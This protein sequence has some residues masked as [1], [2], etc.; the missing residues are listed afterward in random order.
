MLTVDQLRSLANDKQIETVYMTFTDHIGRQMG[1][2]YDVD[3]FLEDGIAGSYA[4]EYLLTVD[5]DFN[6]LPG[7]SYT[8]WD[9]GYGDFKLIPDLSTLRHASWLDKTAYVTCDVVNPKTKGLVPIAPRSILRKQIGRLQEAGYTAVGASELEY[10]MYKDSYEEAFKKGYRGLESYGYYLA[11]YHMLQSTREEKLNAVMRRHLKASG[12]PVE[13]SKG[14][15]GRGQHELNVRYADVLTMSDRHTVYKQ[16]FK[17]VASQMGMSVTF[18]A[19]PHSDQSGNSCHL[20]V[21]LAD[22]NGRNIFAGNEDFYGIKCSPFFRYFLGGWIKHTPSLMPFYAPTINSYKRFA[23]ASWAPTRLGWSA[24]N[25][26]AG[27][28]IVG[29]GP[30]LRIECRLPGAD[31]NPYLA[32]SA[33]VASGL[34]GILNKIEPDDPGHENLDEDPSIPLLPRTLAEATSLFQKSDF[35]RSTFGNDVVDHYAHFFD[36]ECQSFDRAVTD[37]ERTRYFEQI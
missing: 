17:E 1:K 5:T 26:T 30:S 20:H 22:P 28:R 8:N 3:Y 24:D 33:A 15:Y 36:S 19:K 18:M 16:S 35:A 7:F 14:E 11:D 2:R 25:R 34:D 21:N 6:I 27:F 37:W 31:A 10:F 4:C 13:S 12:V 29:E 9:V 23:I 32:F